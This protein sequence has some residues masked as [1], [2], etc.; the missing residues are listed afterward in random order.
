MLRLVRLLRLAKLAE[1]LNIDKV[2]HMMYGLT[3]NLGMTRLQLEFYFRVF[4]LVLIML[5]TAHGLGCAWLMIGRHNVFETVTAGGWMIAEYSQYNS[6]GHFNLN[7]TKDYI[8]CIGGSFDDLDWNAVHGASCTF[9]SVAVPVQ[10]ENAT[11]ADLFNTKANQVCDPVP[12]MNPFDVDCSWIEDKAI[13]PGAT[14][15]APGVGAE[16]GTQ[17][18]AAF[19]FSLVTLSTVGYGDI[20]P[21]T[22]LEKDFVIMAIMLGA[23]LYAYIIGEFSDLISN[24][25]KEKSKFEAKMRSVNDLLAYIDAPLEVRGKV[26]EFYEFKF[27]NKEGQSDLLDEL[28]IAL[29]T[30]VV[31][32][33]WG[34]LISQ[35]PFFAGLKD[36]PITELCKRMVKFTVAPGD[37]IMENGEH[38]DELLMLAKGQACTIPDSQNPV[39]EFD[40]GTF[41]G[42]LQFL[43]LVEDRQLTVMATSYCEIASLEPLGIADILN[44]NDGLRVRLE[45]YGAMR[46]EIE[47]KIAAGIPFDMEVLQKNLESKYAEAQDV[48]RD[49]QRFKQGL[50]KAATADNILQAVN[51]LALTSDMEIQTINDRMS[52]VEQHLRRAVRCQLKIVCMT[53]NLLPI[54]RCYIRLCCS[55]KWSRFRKPVPSPSISLW[56][57]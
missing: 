41:W 18:L 16:E 28:P 38:H 49:K 24:M 3:K 46:M 45:S 15:A 6:D 53:T 10:S 39:T 50:G 42:E 48:Q 30:A 20:L 56:K 21:R 14:G 13:I 33:R 7:K 32:H 19:Y 4:F 43:G 44:S 1:L 27:V 22:S 55:G 9:G 11:A 25:K 36:G 2:V 8:M 40:P 23:F 35:V 17:Y 52:M 31:K 57:A 47:E 37:L 29:Q 12:E 34:R 5:G 54:Y 26:Q 51:E